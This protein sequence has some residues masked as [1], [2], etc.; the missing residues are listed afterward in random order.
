MLMS[1]M[2]LCFLLGVVC[3]L[4][5]MMAPAAI[6]WGARLGWLHFAGSKIGFIDNPIT[7]IVFTLFAVGELVGDKLPKAPAR[8]AAPGLITRIVFGG[9][10]AGALAFSAGAGVSIGVVAGVAGAIAGTYG[11]Y[12]V[13]RAL[14]TK[15]KLPDFPVALVEDLIAIVAAYLIISHV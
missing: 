6:C 2:I 7:L 13:R 8:T 14:T 15:G 1:V 10:C 9:F 5:S 3:G 4:R 11:G 12:L